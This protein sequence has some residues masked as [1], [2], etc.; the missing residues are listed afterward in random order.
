M[1][2]TY[3]HIEFADIEREPVCARHV[4]V[5]MKARLLFLLFEIRRLD[6]LEV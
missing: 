5:C 6:L 4:F 3:A 1:P 2:A